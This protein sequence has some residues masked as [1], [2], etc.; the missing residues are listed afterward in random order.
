MILLKDEGIEFDPKYL[1]E[2]YEDNQ[3][4]PKKSV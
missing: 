2:F 1:Y 4:G 3:I